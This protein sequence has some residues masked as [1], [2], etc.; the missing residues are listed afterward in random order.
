MNSTHESGVS[1][2]RAVALDRPTPPVPGLTAAW[3]QPPSAVRV[4]RR[5]PAGVEI[6][7]W[8][9]GAVAPALAPGAAHV[10]RVRLNAPPPAPELRQSLSQ[11]EVRRADRFHFARDRDFFVA[12]RSA[13]RCILGAYLGARPGALRFDYGRQGKPSLA[14]GPWGRN[15]IRFNLSHSH[16][17]MLCAVARGREVGI[18]LEHTRSGL[19]GL[20]LA[21]RVFSPREMAALRS[22]P[23]SRQ[24][25]SFYNCWTRKEAYIKADGRGVTLPL[26]EFDVSLAPGEPA[27]LLEHRG[28]PSEVSRWELLGLA[29]APDY[30][31]AL[32]LER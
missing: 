10:W 26:K 23:A 12:A 1:P 19:A 30:V 29:P 24:A 13:L 5:P 25:E 22:V 9:A 2:R 18:D 8:G 14:G 16:E 31:G 28:D 7:S 27:M 32:V 21:G 20:H 3:A 17:L 11:D 15:D 4:T 6:L